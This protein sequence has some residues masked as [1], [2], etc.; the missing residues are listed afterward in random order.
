MIQY[1][2]KKYNE[3][4]VTFIIYGLI[5]NYGIFSVNSSI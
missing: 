2:Y 5:P 1:F 4:V 3:F